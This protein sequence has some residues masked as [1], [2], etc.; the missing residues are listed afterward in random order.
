ME[1]IDDICHWYYYFEHLVV[2]R[3]LGF[4]WS[5][6]RAGPRFPV[7]SPWNVIML[8]HSNTRS[9]WDIAIFGFV[10]KFHDAWVQT[11]LLQRPWRCRTY[12][13]LLR[14]CW[15]QVWRHQIHSR[16]MATEEE[17]YNDLQNRR[18]LR[19]FS[20]FSLS[21]SLLFSNHGISIMPCILCV[22]NSTN[23][24]IRSEF[25]YWYAWMVGRRGW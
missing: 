21:F 14:C 18:R 22:F 3:G 24:F 2:P 17:R 1:A 20:P 5:R 13:T 8:S 23:L 25:I 16:R 15:C 9:L 19:N 4:L 7:L 12:K 6:I 10:V 11:T